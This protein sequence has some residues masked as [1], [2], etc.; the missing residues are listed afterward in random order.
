MKSLISTEVAG[1]TIKGS[2]NESPAKLT[3][4]KSNKNKRFNATQLYE[5]TT[6]RFYYGS[7]TVDGGFQHVIPGVGLCTCRCLSVFLNIVLSALIQLI[8]YFN[9][10]NTQIIIN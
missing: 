1:N 9:I 4:W 8:K 5:H 7:N 3:E 10:L 6:A 2:M